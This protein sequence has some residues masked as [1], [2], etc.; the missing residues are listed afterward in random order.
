MRP[1]W[2]SDLY[3]AGGLSGGRGSARPRRVRRFSRHEP[4]AAAVP[5]D[6]QAEFLQILVDAQ[7]HYRVRDLRTRFDLPPLAIFAQTPFPIGHDL[8]SS[9]D[10]RHVAANSREGSDPAL[11]RHPE[12]S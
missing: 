7:P 12:F 9:R 4:V 1:G 3:S 8:N 2:S 11:P 10:W 6:A 5:R